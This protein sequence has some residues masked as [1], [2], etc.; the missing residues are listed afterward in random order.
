MTGK[1]LKR[2]NEKSGIP[3]PLP[4]LKPLSLFIRGRGF[5]SGTLVAS[6]ML[7]A[8]VAQAGPEGGVVVSGQGDVEKLSM[9]DTRI[10]QHSQNLF[11]N[12]S[13]FDVAADESVLIS[14]P[15]V[16][17][18][19]VARIVGGSATAIFGSITANG[20]V[21]FINSRGVIFGETATLDAASV[22]V[23]TLTPQN[24][25]LFDGDSVLLSEPGATGS[26]VNQGVIQAATGGSVTLLGETI[27]NEGIIRATLGQVTL[28]SGSE[29]VVS[30][31]PDQLLGVQVTREVL[32]NHEG[33]QAAVSN[34]GTIEASGGQILLSGEVSRGL[35]DEAVN[36]DGLLKATS[37]VYEN[38]VITLTASGGNLVNTGSIDVSAA[39]PTANAGVVRLMSDSEIIIDD[40]GLLSANAWQ[41]GDGGS[42]SVEGAAV[43]VNGDIHARGGSLSGNGGLVALRATESLTFNGLVDASAP[44]GDRGTLILEAPSLTVSDQ[45][46]DDIAA[47]SLE[48]SRANLDLRAS[49]SIELAD[50]QQ[51]QLNLTDRNVSLMVTGEAGLLES[52]WVGFRMLGADDQLRVDGSFSLEVTDTS[53]HANA[54]IDIAGTIESR[55]VRPQPDQ[56]DKP[57]D[58]AITANNGRIRIR[59]TA[60]LAATHSDT[61]VGDSVDAASE[62]NG[63]SLV[64]LATGYDGNNES[65][66]VII[67]G[68]I[69]ASS[70]AGVGGTVKLLGDRI[71]LAGNAL[72][73]VSGATGGGTLLV[74]GNYQ[75]EGAEPNALRTFVGANVRLSADALSTGDGGRVIVWSDEST[76]FYGSVSARG[77]SLDGDGGFVEISGK[78]LDNAGYF[79]LRAV[80]GDGGTLL[81]DPA[82]I[83]ITAGSADGDDNDT[84]GANTRKITLEEDA[85]GQV[86]FEPTVGVFRVYESE[87]EGTA[88]NIILQATDSIKV[89]GA[90]T[91]GLVVQP[92]FDISLETR[93]ASGE[94]SAGI[95][96]TGG[97]SFSIAVSGGG[98]ISISAGTDGGDVGM[99]QLTVGSLSVS[100]S[101]TI[102]LA[103]E[104][105]IFVTDTLSAGSGGII[106][107]TQEGSIIIDD[108]IIGVS[109]LINLASTGVLA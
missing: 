20:Q 72:V 63:G 53:L 2:V 37:G 5:L 94:G 31:G 48:N 80:A 84:G 15:D 29:A 46:T 58:M 90:F 55:P 77:G 10:N 45:G 21:A 81:F 87:I 22:L 100:G 13:S 36:N 60:R 109:T 23:S 62:V 8:M 107:S 9:L 43:T 32:E 3:A 82:S 92:G 71:G 98:S 16:S 65:G 103:A 47:I 88:A 40:A 67:E 101:G 49:V 76:R 56:P 42:I 106:I 105:S 1:Q 24:A 59:E 6:H 34:S 39:E 38:G 54:L 18:W 11:M 61:A 41:E 14:Q 91:G 78:H 75:G 52:E 7:L 44:G 17:S 30:F 51:N 83:E 50:L 104:G 12:F 96:L 102:S 33:L 4:E 108:G 74:G 64:L 93:N 57:Y 19:F 97:T 69:D 25:L 68:V 66:T 79:D 35:F 26:V 86:L 70:K 89:V 99:A 85:L 28:S 73:D 27:S 95:D